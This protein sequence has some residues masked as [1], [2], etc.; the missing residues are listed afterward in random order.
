[1]DI[2]IGQHFKVLRKLSQTVFSSIYLAEDTRD[3]SKIVLKLESKRSK[4]KQLRDEYKFYKKFKDYFGFP[5]MVY[6]GRESDYQVLGIEKFD[7]NLEELLTRCHRRFSMKTVL[8]LADQMISR[9][10][11]MHKR[12]YVH[13]DLKPENFMIRGQVLYLIDFGTVKRYRDASWRHI[14]ATRDAPFVGSTRFSSIRSLRN[15]ESSRRDDMEAIGYILMYFLRGSLPWIGIV[16]RHFQDQA[17]KIATM[18]EKVTPLTLCRGVPSEFMR[19]FEKVMRLN[20]EEEPDY[21]GYR[22][23]FRELGLR[24]NICY[25]FKYDWDNLEEE[26]AKMPKLIP[27]SQPITRLGSPRQ[28]TFNYKK[29]MKEPNL[30]SLANSRMSSKKVSFTEIPK[31]ARTSLQS[32]K[33][34]RHRF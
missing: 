10:E 17:D 27:Y 1:M 15:Y 24:E 19:Y 25:D 20:H 2:F 3:S 12:G 33:G 23:M 29:L 22:K 31:L 26:K 4:I 5:R 21:A 30:P 7:N 18:K 9:V 8:L 32:P 14:P 6:Y 34:G 16:G 13:K 11:I 28:K